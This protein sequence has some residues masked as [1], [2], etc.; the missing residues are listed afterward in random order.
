MKKKTNHHYILIVA[1]GSGTR[2]YPRSREDK[3]KQFH[4]IIGKKTLIEQTFDRA[5]KIVDAE[6]IYISVN[7]KYFSLVR[8]FLPHVPVK[9]IIV[10][11]VKRN[12]A[13]AMALATAIIGK[14]DPEAVIAS[15]HSDHLILRPS[16][17]TK[18]I[19]T[20]FDFVDNNKDIIA[21]IGIHPTSP[22]T[23]YGYIER[24]DRHSELGDF[25]AY[26]VAKFVEKPNRDKA[27]EYLNKGGFYW[28]AGYFVWSAKHFLDELSKFQPVISKGVL[29]VIKEIDSSTYNQTL[30][31]EF[32]KLPNIAIDLAIMEKTRKLV[33][34]PA[35][36]GWSDVGSWDS[37]SDLLDNDV[38]TREG[39]YIEGL[40]VPLDTHNSVI[41]SNSSKK[42]VAT[43]GLDN[44]IVI[45]TDDALIIS[46]K[47]RTEEVKYIVE[48]LKSRKLDHLL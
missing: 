45:V 6:H 37:V 1:G 38:K 15:L 33:V 23:G 29:K 41:L 2:L 32:T 11:P 16:I 3:P 22:H 18:V 26:S 28:N 9:N 24:E 48:E 4:P 10:E 20:A 19:K 13:P 31:K 7:K 27:L 17:F 21:T 39:N 5:R 14:R 36:L 40:V 47:G 42:L 12:T 34:V 8:E 25:T 30:D 43:I 44:I 35:D 46:Q